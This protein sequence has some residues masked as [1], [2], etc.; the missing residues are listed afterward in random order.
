MPVAETVTIKPDMRVIHPDHGDITEDVAREL[1]NLRREEH[2]QLVRNA[3][4]QQAAI[5]QA[6]P[7]QAY[8]K[9]S[10]ALKAEIDPQV[11][12]YWRM[13]EGPGFWKNELDW[14]LKKNP[15]CRVKSV[16]ENPTVRVD[17]FKTAEPVRQAQGF[18]PRAGRKG[19]WAL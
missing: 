4:Q 18:S 2:E 16:A 14:F 1:A 13:R 11:H 9:R 6:R 15:E 7:G 17:G 12:A 3:A 8:I 10:F 19:R 5:V